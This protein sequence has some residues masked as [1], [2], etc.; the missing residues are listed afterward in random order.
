MLTVRI[1]SLGR[2]RESSKRPLHPSQAIRHEGIRITVYTSVARAASWLFCTAV[3]IAVGLLGFLLILKQSSH[4]GAFSYAKGLDPASIA[5][6]LLVAFA[7]ALF[8]VG[9]QIAAMNVHYVPMGGALPTLASGDAAAPKPHAAVRRA[10]FLGHRRDRDFDF[11]LAARL[12]EPNTSK[13]LNR[14]VQ[15]KSISFDALDKGLDVLSEMAQPPGTM[16]REF[17]K[18]QS[19]QAEEKQDL[20]PVV[21]LMV[22]RVLYKPS[23]TATHKRTTEEQRVKPEV[24]GAHLYLVFKLNL[25]PFCYWLLLLAICLLVPAVALEAVGK[26][27]AKEFSA[28]AAVLVLMWA[29]CTVVFNRRLVA[30]WRRWQEESGTRPLGNI[31]L[32]LYAPSTDASSSKWEELDMYDFQ[33]PL[34]DYVMDVNAMFQLAVGFFAGTAF[35]F[36]RLLA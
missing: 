17:A 27:L 23:K 5:S 29:L 22:A 33:I 12:L 14:Y 3:L 9:R 21:R 4:A 34:T 30:R 25:M 7:V 19:G 2:A 31:P 16:I 15:R 13:R 26:E 32:F 35:S 8:A 20:W 11:D 1:R 6:F 28:A 18:R 36:S 24:K 10:R